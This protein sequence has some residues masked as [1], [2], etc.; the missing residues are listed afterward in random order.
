MKT[1]TNLAFLGG[2]YC[3]LKGAGELTTNPSVAKRLIE[4]LLDPVSSVKP[5]LALVFINN[6]AV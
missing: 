1:G 6:S 2:G 4:A 5:R 3:K